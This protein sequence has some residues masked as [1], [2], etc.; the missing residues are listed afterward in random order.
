MNAVQQKL[1]EIRARNAAQ[2]QI[3]QPTQPQQEQPMNPVRAKLLEIR[4]RNAAQAGQP[5]SQPTGALAPVM[6]QKP[7]EQNKPGLLRR[8]AGAAGDVV[9][10]FGKGVLDAPREFASLGADLGTKFGETGIGRKLGAGIR[11]T[12]GGTINP[13]TARTLQ[14]GLQGGT[15][16]TNFTK[17]QNTAQKI[18]FGAEKIA[19]FF[20]PGGA[21]GKLGKVV[22]DAGVA[23]K[24]PRAG[25]FLGATTKAITEAGLA[26][27]QTATQEGKLDDSALAAGGVSLALPIAGKVLKT[28]GKVASE[29]AQFMASKLSGVPKAAIEHA[30]QNPVA[31]RGA[32]RQ[33]SKDVGSPQTVLAHAEDALNTIKEVRRSA[34]KENL[35]KVMSETMQNKNG[36][37]YVKRLITPQDVRS[38][39][40]PKNA[41]GQNIFVPTDFSLKGVKDTVTK[42]L[43]DFGASAKGQSVVFEK[44]PL[45][46]SFKKELGEVVNKIYKWDDISPTGLDDLREIID[47]YKKTGANT[48]EK[49]FNKIVGDIRSN[50]SKYVGDR[51]PQIRE[52][53]KQYAQQS[54]VI[55]G[56][57]KELSVGKDKP[58]TALRKL[59]NVFN[60]KSEAYR[61]YVQ[62]LGDEAGRDLM[63]EIA[64]LTMSKW[65]PEGIGAYV[66]GS[67]G[68]G[69]VANPSVLLAA[70]FASPRIVGETA[71]FAGKVLPKIKKATNSNILPPAARGVASQILQ[72]KKNK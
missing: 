56:L 22:S 47:V 19:E 11:S 17:P 18:G 10:G 55:D 29:V 26:A 46:N 40:A 41:V 37:W 32:I 67:V 4:A 53:N 24:L 45:P 59:L 30:I 58:T 7:A 43:K 13:E 51:V 64:G 21:A 70:P 31:A 9:V 68:L 23:A 61:P 1:M 49:K 54:D 34:Y 2:Q 39:L 6:I 15:E 3:P 38:G 65:T 62:Q 42:T 28:G 20:V 12:L 35:G 50:I 27:G 52:M 44:V 36:Q 72:N 66:A 60:P 69:A 57:M 71:A 48:A 16:Q 8:A 5:V 14:A 63:S 25:K 33:F